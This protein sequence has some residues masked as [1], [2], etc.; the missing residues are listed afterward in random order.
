MSIVEASELESSLLMANA[1]LGATLVMS[2]R[3]RA[4][5]IGHKL[6]QAQAL[7]LEAQGLIENERPNIRAQKQLPLDKAL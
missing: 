2:Q 3:T 4:L 7:L 6:A 1:H 5:S